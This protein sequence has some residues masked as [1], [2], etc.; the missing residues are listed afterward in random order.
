MFT[1]LEQRS[2][3]K[4][5]VARCRSKLECFR[6][7][8]E[9]CEDAVLPYRTVAQWAKAFW[10]GGYAVQ[11]NLLTG[12]SHVENNNSSTACLPVGCWSPESGF[13]GFSDKC[14]MCLKVVGGSNYIF[15]SLTSEKWLILSR[16]LAIFLDFCEILN[17]HDKNE[18]FSFFSNFYIYFS[19]SRWVT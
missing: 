5:K 16:I 15:M 17:I 4:I 1:K 2:W 19:I 9:A 8:R 10:E 18:I 12:R 3:I 7:L 6:G 13:F 14:E 11:D